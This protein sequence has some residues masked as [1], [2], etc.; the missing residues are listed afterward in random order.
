MKL[1]PTPSFPCEKPTNFSQVRHPSSKIPYSCKTN[2]LMLYPFSFW[3]LYCRKGSKCNFYNYRK[4]EQISITEIVQQAYEEFGEGDMEKLAS[5]MSD[6]YVGRL[7]ESLPN[8]GTFNGPNDFIQNCLAKNSTNYNDWEGSGNRI[9]FRGENEF[10]KFV[11]G[12]WR[13]SFPFRTFTPL[14]PHNHP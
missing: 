7:P 13:M 11:N 8:G 12:E 1:N 2:R 9:S 4:K 3:T 10:R 6:S 14:L 5:L